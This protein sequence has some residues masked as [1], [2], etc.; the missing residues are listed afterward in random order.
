M[1]LGERLKMLRKQKRIS[2]EEMA[3]RLNINRGTYAQYEIDRRSPD[4]ETLQMIADYFNVSTDYLFGRTKKD[5]D[6]AELEQKLRRGEITY[7]GE[8]LTEEQCE[9]LSDFLEAVV[10]RRKRRNPNRA[11]V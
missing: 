8:P 6:L 11:A 3:Q 7:R 9:I 5:R 10:R 2:Q 1:T 4:Y